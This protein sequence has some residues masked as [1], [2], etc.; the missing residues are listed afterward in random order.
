MYEFET[1]QRMLVGD[2]VSHHRRLRGFGFGFELYS[3]VRA[4]VRWRYVRK[5]VKALSLQQAF[6]VDESN[7]EKESIVRSNWTEQ[8]WKLTISINKLLPH[9]RSCTRYVRYMEDDAGCIYPT[10]HLCHHLFLLQS[11]HCIR[12]TVFLTFMFLYSEYS[13]D[14]EL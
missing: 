5:H 11:S 10:I 2:E 7:V 6:S 4:I 13:I 3:I 14:P 12:Y 1:C 9:T 8:D